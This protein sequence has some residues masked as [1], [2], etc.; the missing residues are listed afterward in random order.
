[1]IVDLKLCNRTKIGNRDYIDRIVNNQLAPKQS[2]THLVSTHKSDFDRDHTLKFKITYKS[3]RKTYS[4]IFEFNLSWN[5]TM[6]SI[7]I[8]NADYEKQFIELYQDEIRKKL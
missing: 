6:P 1:M 5:S 4:D 7:S 8:S 3:G 2:I